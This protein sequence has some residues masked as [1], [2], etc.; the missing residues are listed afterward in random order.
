M[1]DLRF[2]SPVYSD[3][4]SSNNK[5]IFCHGGRLNTSILWKNPGMEFSLEIKAAQKHR[6]ERE[7]RI[8]RV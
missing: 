7:K 2:V 4:A 3:T 1:V 6:D 8:E 5:G